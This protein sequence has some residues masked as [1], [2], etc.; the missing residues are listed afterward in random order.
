M[1]G[2]EGQRSE[3]LMEDTSRYEW[4]DRTRFKGW[5]CQK[6]KIVIFYLLWSV[7]ILMKL[8]ALL[9]VAKDE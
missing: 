8:S 5:F 4:A 3:R 2:R 1:G 7:K 9:K 6:K